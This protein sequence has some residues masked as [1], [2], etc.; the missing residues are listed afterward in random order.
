MAANSTGTLTS[1]IAL[2]R[3]TTV[4]EIVPRQLPQGGDLLVRR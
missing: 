3:L 4:S 1:I 2:R